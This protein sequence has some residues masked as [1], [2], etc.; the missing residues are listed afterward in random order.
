MGTFERSTRLRLVGSLALRE[1]AVEASLRETAH[2][3]LADALTFE[4]LWQLPWANTTRSPDSLCE[5][6]LAELDE[7]GGPG[8]SC[9]E[10]L[11]KAAGHLTAR[12][13][14]KRETRDPRGGFRDWRAVEAVL[15][16]MHRTPHGLIV[17]AEAVAAGRRGDAARALT[18]DGEPVERVAGDVQ[19]MDNKWL[20][21][22]LWWRGRLPRRPG[23][24]GD[25]AASRTDAPRGDL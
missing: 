16:L 20:R 6:A 4:D 12:G 17:L 13:W 9:R 25:P 3:A 15:N 1:F 22:L 18:A 8:P 19:P 21:G 7:R 23:R 24:V 11:V 5:A 2:L 10:L 14:L